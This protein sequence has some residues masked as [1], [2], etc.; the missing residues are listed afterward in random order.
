MDNLQQQIKAY[1]QKRGA[2]Y[3]TDLLREFTIN[4]SKEECRRVN[5]AVA[6]L[7]HSGEMT[8]IPFEPVSLL[9]LSDRC[10]H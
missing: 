10:L 8:C 9:A 3:E 5:T 2:V 6:Y 1:V 4:E 7:I